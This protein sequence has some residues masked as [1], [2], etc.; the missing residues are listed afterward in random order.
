MQ[1]M[2]ITKNLAIFIYV[3]T[4]KE[5]KEEL[6]NSANVAVQRANKFLKQLD[7]SLHIN[8][9]YDSWSYN[10]LDNAIGVYERDSVF[11]G[12][13]S[14][15]FNINNLYKWF[16]KETKNNPWSDEYTILDEAIQTNVFHEMGHGIIQLLND[17]LQETDDLDELYDNNQQFFD[18]ILDNEED[19]VEEFAWAMY[20][21]QLE[22]C[23]LYNMIQLYL[24]W[25]NSQT[26]NL[27]ERLARRV[28]SLFEDKIGGFSYGNRGDSFYTQEK[29]IVSELSNYDLSG[30]I[31]YCNCDNPSMSNFYKFFKN[32]FNTL[33]LKGLYATYFDENPKMF[34][35]NGSQEMS[36]PISS[37]RF[38]DNGEIM[39]RCDIVIT[40]P[41][42][43]N[44]MASELVKMAQSYGKHVIMVGPLSMAYQKEMFEL[45]KNNQ[46]NMG[47]TTINTYNKP[48]G[49]SGNAPTAW[50][51]TMNVN[52]PSFQT[53]VK[54]NPS[55]YQKYDN[56]D[57]IDIPAYDK[58]LPDDYYGY[59]GVSPRMLRVLNR[60]QFDIITKIRPVINGKVKNEKYIIKRKNPQQNLAE[61][62]SDR[63]L[64][65]VHNVI[66]ENFSISTI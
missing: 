34:F 23:G 1:K 57:A 39:K 58:N 32:N 54:F 4:K 46:L 56:F 65:I 37:G 35:F 59:M 41:P 22:N 25:C 6:K 50:W 52:R 21:N 38:Q 64:E 45:I 11:G 55:K 10:D 19:S 18:N 14:I 49:E 8:W 53:G 12:D 62:L 27:S 26:Q 33:G 31:I 60:N 7:L 3:M 47:Y 5:F 24:N 20:D 13:I 51:T 17:Y 43:S 29:N 61:S 40:N 48:G 28:I 9:E 44:S 16:V 36:Q 15:G 2:E 66:F 63:I 42:F 30:K